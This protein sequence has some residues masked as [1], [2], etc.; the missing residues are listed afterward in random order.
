MCAGA[1]Q[2]YMLV[3]SSYNG[4]HAKFRVEVSFAIQRL[5]TIA[6]TSDKTN[7]HLSTSIGLAF[8]RLHLQK[9]EAPSSTPANLLRLAWLTTSKHMIMCGRKNNHTRFN[10]RWPTTHSYRLLL[11]AIN[12]RD[13]NSITQDSFSSL[14][15]HCWHSPVTGTTVKAYLAWSILL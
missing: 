11:A 2:G 7:S 1:R 8:S 15:S 3:R 9:T 14:N 6:S 10:I 13:G 4:G 5:Q 12:W